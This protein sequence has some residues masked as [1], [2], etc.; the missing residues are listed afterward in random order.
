MRCQ[1]RSIVI[2]AP[3]AADAIATLGTLRWRCIAGYG[4]EAV[5]S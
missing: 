5:T 2:A 4:G 1:R 3:W